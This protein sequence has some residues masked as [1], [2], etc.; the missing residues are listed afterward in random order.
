MRSAGWAFRKK[1][2]SHPV[3][4]DIFPAATQLQTV[5]VF[6]LERVFNDGRMAPLSVYLNE[7]LWG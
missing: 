4:F 3:V 1:R 6:L 2:A 7:D 5:I